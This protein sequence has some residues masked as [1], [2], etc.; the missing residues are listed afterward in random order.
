MK[1]LRKSLLLIIALM[2]LG[3]T[4][5]AQMY[6]IATNESQLRGYL[7]NSTTNE[8]R[9]ENDISLSNSNLEISNEADIIDLNGFT[10]DCKVY[11][12]K[13]TAQ[14][15]LTIRETNTNR[16]G[17]VTSRTNGSGSLF[18]VSENA[19]LYIEGGNISAQRSG[20]TNGGAIY[21]TGTLGIEGGTIS[22]GKITNG[23]ATTFGGGVY[24][25]GTMTLGLNNNGG[26]IENC[27]AFFNGGGI[28]NTGTLTIN[29]GTIGGFDETNN[30]SLGNSASEGGGIINDE[31]I[32]NINGGSISYNSAIDE[33]G[34]GISD[35]YGTINING[36][37]ISDNTAGKDYGG[38]YV[39][40]GDTP[41]SFIMTGGS[42]ANNSADN[43]YGG[44][45][46]R[47][48]M[49]M[50]GGSVT[51]NSAANL[52]GGI[53]VDG[54]LNM[55]GN[56]IVMGNT[57]GGNS[58]NVRL[59]SADNV[60]RVITV[61][62]AFTSGASVGVTCQYT[63]NAAFTWGL[64]DYTHEQGSVF[65]SDNTAYTVTI[66]NGEAKLVAYNP[67]EVNGPVP[68][69]NV[70]ANGD[71]GDAYCLNYTRMSDLTDN[72]NG[73][74]LSGSTN[75]GWYVVDKNLTFNKRITISGTV[76]IIL[77]DN[78][79]LTANKGIYVPY[80]TTLHIWAQ[81][82]DP[83][84]LGC[85]VATANEKNYAGIG[86][87]RGSGAGL[88]YFH[89]GACSGI[90][91]ENAAGIN[92]AAYFGENYSVNIYGGN[93]FGIGGDYGAGIGGGFTGMCGSILITGGTVIGIG[94]INAAGIGSGYAGKNHDMEGGYSGNTGD[95]KTFIRI[96]GGNVTGWGTSGAGIG[97]GVGKDTFDGDPALVYEGGTVEAKT[98]DGT[99]ITSRGAIAIG[100]GEGY[101]FSGG[102]DTD[103]LEIYNGAK[104]LAS[105]D[106][107]G[108][109]VL[110][111]AANG[112]S[113]YKTYKK[114][115]IE[116]CN[117]PNGTNYSNNGDSLNVC[118]HCYTK[119]PYTFTTAGNWND[120]GNWLGSIT[121]GEGKDVAV[122]A[123]A[124]IPS[125]YCAHVGHIDMQEGGSLTIE[126]GGQ[127]IHSSSVIATV[128]KDILGYATSGSGDIGGWNFIA[129]PIAAGT[130]PSM[131]NGLL[132]ISG[133]SNYDLYYYD[134]PAHHW[135]NHKEN[136]NTNHPNANPNF[137]LTNG[138]GYLYAHSNAVELQFE[139]T[140]Q[141]GSSYNATY[142]VDDLSYACDN[143]NLK[144]FNLVGNPFACNATIDK[145]CYTLTGNAISTTAQE[146]GYVIPPCTGVMVKAEGANETVTFTK[147]IPTTQSTQPN[148]G[149]L[150]IMLSQVNT[151]SNALLDNA[152]VSFT[153]G[154]A[155]EK[156]VFNE[157]NA[158][159]YIPQDGKDYAIV[160][161]E[162]QGELPL[163]FKA[164]ADGQYTIAVAPEGV[165]MAYLHLIDNMTGADIDLLH[166]NAVIAG[167]DPQSPTPAYTFTAKT[168]DYESRFKLVFVSSICEDANG[169]NE[170]F[171]FYSNGNWIIN[172]E[173]NSTLQVIDLNGRILSSETINGS[174]SKAINAA[175]G[176]YM[177][178]LINGENVKVQKI[179]V[180]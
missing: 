143:E 125:N 99:P 176:V 150:Q 23:H 39:G 85:I 147:V 50:T 56:P 34:V 118:N 159:L 36:G 101:L 52:Y 132:D 166:P 107:N 160:I 65:A 146:I 152:I 9:L 6:V 130:T 177:L 58:E 75:G 44:I 115:K 108:N 19:W 170:T 28:Y 86:G 35:F 102:G 10:L 59:S 30:V 162:G 180:R 96:T 38:V 91:G 48:T 66:D 94:G 100:W 129:T 109:Y 26:S 14:G 164:N 93:V 172:N 45:R 89:G 12:I 64:G 33:G 120:Q 158:K 144:G 37:S 27:E 8:I 106:N 61:N 41:S 167:E 128:K 25:T 151:R 80:N 63:T 60:N 72:G 54:T 169:D 124:T 135:R 74:T 142:I 104:V 46:V 57:A 53:D 20:I 42:I 148:A 51:G 92:G 29:R 114:I 47:G 163:N 49:T 1:N 141:A 133:N 113:N 122:K 168:T 5:R 116:P 98:M 123:A 173:G 134:K 149:S 83:N 21:N 161:S 179:V 13:V 97:G 121:P 119:E 79:R 165:E 62:G 110:Q 112:R 153:E 22:G 127:L 81:S 88:L 155:L 40:G 78:T 140:L 90:G 18:D 69:F 16:T 11:Q 17:T 154:N 32:I 145:P 15:S 87:H 71:H 68:Y 76:N 103:C 55:S 178:R 126:D 70:D 82:A 31:G 156:F 4:A 24:N 3:Q 7:S 117:H 77:M 111:S 157:D 131:N 43:N 137:M 73:V 138:Q 95:E 171:A 67:G 105:T 175:P 2:A 174:A 136:N 139:C 84:D